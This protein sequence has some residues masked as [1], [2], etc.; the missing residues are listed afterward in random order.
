VVRRAERRCPRDPQQPRRWRRTLNERRRRRG[1]RSH[2]ERTT[3][4][5]QPVVITRTQR[6]NKPTFVINRS[7]NFINNTKHKI[8]FEK[9][10]V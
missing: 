3:S 7:N 9:Q 2:N 10:D 1:Q 8:K 6:Q 5:H 4:C